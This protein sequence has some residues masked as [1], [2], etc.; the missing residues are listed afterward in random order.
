MNQPISPR[1]LL[2][3]DGWGHRDEADANAI[4]LAN[5]PVWDKLLADYPHTLIHTSGLKV[6][7]PEGQMGNSEVGHMNLG[8]GR[9]VYQNLTRINKA[10]SDGDFFNNPGFVKTCQSVN[11]AKGALHIIGLLSPGGIHSHEDQIEAMIDMAIQQGCEKIYLHALLDGR[12][13]PPRSAESSLA[14]FSDKL[15]TSAKGQIASVSGRFYAMDRDNRW[16]RVEQAYKS[17]A[18]GESDFHFENALDALQSAYARNEDDEF[19]Q[20]SCIH[21]ANSKAIRLNDGDAL[22]FM[23]FRADRARE[24]TRALF[25]V[26][27][28]EFVSHKKVNY[29]AFLTL[30]QYSEDIKAPC[31][32]PPMTL[33]NSLGEFLS[34]HDLTQLRIAETEKYAHVTF[35]FSGGREKEFTGE[36]RILVPSPQVKTYDLKPE[37]SAY[38]VCEKLVSAIKNREY[39]AIICNF[40]NGDMVGHT[41]NVDAT[42][43]A[44]EVVDECVEALI[45][46]VH[47]L[48]GAVIYTADHGNADVMYTEKDGVRSP[49]TSHTL[50]PVPFAI[51]CNTAAKEL[52]LIK[53]EDAGLTNIAATVMNLL[54]YQAP[55]DYQPSL[56]ALGN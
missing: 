17:I 44:M 35:F 48:N 8:A 2:I 36:T 20:P 12:D 40:A 56:L 21:S 24:L 41:G 37:M 10:I 26:D 18:L 53:H 46:V 45:N 31:A 25:D 34:L 4:R 42:V 27:F 32:Y 28:S 47:K 13:T 14:K 39:A 9:V 6:G 38:E 52:S 30:T 43:K 15:E 19:V 50:N 11:A 3:L 55:D 23:N 5:T 33:T 16:D 1:L 54:G 7:L 29:S 49:K 51:S 22:I